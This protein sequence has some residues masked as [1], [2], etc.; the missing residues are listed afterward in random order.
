MK[1]LGGFFFFSPSLSAPK[2]LTVYQPVPAV[3]V[4][5]LAYLTETF[6]SSCQHVKTKIS[7]ESS[8]LGLFLE[9]QRVAQHPGK[10]HA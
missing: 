2:R 6:E 4:I 8:D 9:N 1:A 10:L 7:H 3:G 5:H